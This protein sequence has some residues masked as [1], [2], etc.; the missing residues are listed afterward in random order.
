M[1][2]RVPASDRTR[3]QI[4]DVLSGD[5]DKSAL[6]R[7][8]VRLI[9][10]E[11]LEAEV[12]DVLGRGYY[13]RGEPAGYRNGNRL[14]RLKTAEGIVEFAVP[15]VTGTAEP[16]ASEIKQAISGRT[17]EL[18]RLVVEMYARGLSMRDIEA[19]FTG[20]DGRCVLTKSAASQ[21]TER[22]WEDYLA[23]A[24]R[25]L[26]GQPI[27][28]LFL[29]GVAERLHLGQPRE[30]VLAAWGIAASGAKVLLGLYSASKED[31]ASARECLRDLKARGMNEPVLVATDGAPGLIRAVE[32]VFPQSLRQRCLAHKLRNLGAKVPEERWRE[33]KAHALAA[34]QALSPLA[35]R[36]AAEEFRRRY[37]REFPGAVACF[38]DD[39][40]ACI[41]HL[42]LPIAHRKA[43]RT[44]NLLERLFGEERRRTKTIPHAFGERAVLKLMFAALARASQ[45]WRRLVISEFELKQIEE[46]KTELQAEFRQ[47]TAPVASSTAS[48]L[49][50]S[51]NSRT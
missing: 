30:P 40:E 15:Q 47:R 45:S 35:A 11:A 16:W 36:A 43:I 12:M 38:E 8:A 21:V 1:T 46:L 25:D 33:V 17:E 24:G 27:L 18:E 29:D 26:A 19:A 3:K 22:L 32:E 49:H 5:F 37:A 51:S 50:F 48:R 9:V 10:E 2:A 41:A 4:A 34:Y 42:R 20:A 7:N 31:A 39:F 28:Y 23:F 14:G 44:T 13:E 6:L